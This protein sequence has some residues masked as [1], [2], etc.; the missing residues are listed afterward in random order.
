M[1]NRGEFTPKIQ[2]AMEGFFGRQTSRAEFR[3][4]PYI[5]YVMV[6][7]QRI[8]IDKIN[9]EERAILSTLRSEGH[10]EGGASGLALTRDF[11]DFICNVVWMGYVAY[12]EED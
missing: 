10:I 1:A 8:E 4:L 3:L 11:W 7:E 12:R 6:N 2:A 9:P 5:Q